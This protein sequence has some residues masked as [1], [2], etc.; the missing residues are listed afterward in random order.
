MGSL[1]S[2]NTCITTHRYMELG[3]VVRISRITC[4]INMWRC[5][6]VKKEDFWPDHIIFL[7]YKIKI[8][9]I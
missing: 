4:F 9:P 2:Q 5:E 1:N 8:S 6:I 3:G 7:Y